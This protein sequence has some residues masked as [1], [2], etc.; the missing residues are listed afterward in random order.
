LRKHPTFP[1]L[2]FQHL[3]SHQLRPSE[4]YG[5]SRG[6]WEKRAPLDK[7]HYELLKNTACDQRL[8]DEAYGHWVK[9]AKHVNSK[10][11][12][13]Q[14]FCNAENWRKEVKNYDEIRKGVEGTEEEW[15]EFSKKW[16]VKGMAA[17]NKAEK[18]G[19]EWLGFLNEECYAWQKWGLEF[20]VLDFRHPDQINCPHM[21]VDAFL[22]PYDREDDL[23]SEDSD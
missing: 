14:L 15:D 17:M 23:D 4:E 2:A 22:G 5:P 1:E 12:L 9:I 13:K 11:Q 7:I 21:D 10:K 18:E 3:T 8:L 16:M 6:R 20:N 19:K